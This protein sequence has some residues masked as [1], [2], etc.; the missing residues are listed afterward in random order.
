VA[1]V[2]NK[3]TV[4]FLNWST[5]TFSPSFVLRDSHFHPRN[6]EITFCTGCR[7]LSSLHN[8]F[9]SSRLQP[10]TQDLSLGKTLAA[11]GHMPRQ[12]F[13][14]RGGCGQSS[15]FSAAKGNC[16]RRLNYRRQFFAMDECLC[17]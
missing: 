7:I 2:Y 4:N 6:E 3:L 11:A 1:H 13:S 8:D 17:H 12:K 15:Q 16:R 14:A 5:F 10:C 9:S